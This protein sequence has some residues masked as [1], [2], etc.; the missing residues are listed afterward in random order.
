M[1]LCSA[2]FN[3]LF[4]HLTKKPWSSPST[5]PATYCYR[6]NIVRWPLK[7]PR[8]HVTPEPCEGGTSECPRTTLLW[9]DGYESKAPRLNTAVHLEVTI[10]NI[11][12]KAFSLLEHRVKT[13]HLVMYKS[14]ICLRFGLQRVIDRY[15]FRT[16]TLYNLTCQQ[17]AVI[18]FPI[19]RKQVSN[20]LDF[21]GT[22]QAMLLL[23]SK[24]G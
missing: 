2:L 12:I 6:S 9:G 3:P 4:S 10:R 17:H 5:L 18:L 11:C 23:L 22:L 13:V 16:R 20:W 8:N 21:T 24:S 14:C 15:V 7:S 1:C 19:S